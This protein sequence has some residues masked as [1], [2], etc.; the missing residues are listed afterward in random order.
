MYEWVGA[1]GSVKKRHEAGRVG[2]EMYSL[3]SFELTGS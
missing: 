2:E 1:V 3:M